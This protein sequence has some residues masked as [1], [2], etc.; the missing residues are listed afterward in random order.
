VDGQFARA[1]QDDRVPV[2]AVKL[3]DGF[4]AC[5]AP[6]VS[7]DGDDVLEDG[8]FGEGVEEVF[9]VHQSAKSLGDDREEWGERLETRPAGHGCA[10]GTAQAWASLP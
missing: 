3:R 2:A 4:P 9:S 5:D 8:V 10:A 7:G 6:R 1:V